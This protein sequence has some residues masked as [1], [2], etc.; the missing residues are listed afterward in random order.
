MDYVKAN[1]K[2]NYLARKWLKVSCLP[3]SKQRLE[4]YRHAQL[5]DTACVQAMEYCRTR[6]PKKQ[7]AICSDLLPYW[8]ARNSLTMHNNLL[9]YNNRIVIPPSLQAETLQRNHKG[10]QDIE[11]CHMQARSSVWWPKISQHITQSVKQCPV[12][13]KEAFNRSEPL[14]TT[15]LPEYPWQII[16]TD[17]LLW[18]IFHVIRRFLLPYPLV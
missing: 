11:K 14:I 1:S 13:A 18:T 15:P 7:S 16:G 5:M 12:C 3:A 9:L 10:H 2:K 6:W 8:S 17:F 4:T